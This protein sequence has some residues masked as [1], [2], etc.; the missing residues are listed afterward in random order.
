[1][2]I[3]GGKWHNWSG[4][5]V[6]KPKTVLA[7]KDEVELAAAVRTATGMVR[8]PGSGH[9]FTPVAASDGTIID[10]RT[11]GAARRR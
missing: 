8:A 5:V 3:V 2:K 1:M 10:L 6:S 7:P 11:S 9:S 4:G